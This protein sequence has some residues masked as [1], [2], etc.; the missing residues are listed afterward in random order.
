MGSITPRTRKDGSTAYLAQITLKSG[1]KIVHRENQT[2]D[3]RR[4]ATAWMARREE[5]L[6]KPGA[7]D[8]RDDPD[9]G[10][11][12]ERYITE[13]KN[14]PGRTKL[15]VLRSVQK[16]DIA[17]KRCS[18]IGSAE[19][20]ALANHLGSS[21]KPQTVANYLSHLGAVMA[22][23]RPAWGYPLY[24]QAMKDAFIVGKKLGITGK[25][26]ARERRPTLGEL[27]QL[28]E[29]YGDLKKRRP[30]VVDMQAVIAFA[31]F[32]TRRQEEIVTIQWRDLDEKHRRILVRDMKH[33]GDKIGNNQWLDL[34]DEALKIIQGRKRTDTR[35]F[36]YSTDAISASFTRACHMLG[37]IDL[38][39]HDLRHHGVSR[40]F[41][42]GMTIPH[43]AAVSGHRN[44]SSLQRY[45]HIRQQGDCLH[46]W[47]WL[48]IVYN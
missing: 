3:H 43:A 34:P 39:F 33:P 23:A 14:P 31:I 35:I 48:P 9:L 47:K 10:A 45:T 4:N 46:G 5:E 24:P 32:S 22:I 17:S 12:I 36:P 6:T 13:S 29:Y 7:M 40:L 1:G 11:V 30:S 27:D 20:V 15:Q 16:L 28:M 37:I 21:M 25:S 42:M 41:E 2:F 26:T 19:V 38:H 8:R 44:W 18:K